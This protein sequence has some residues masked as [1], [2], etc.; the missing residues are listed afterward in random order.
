MCANYTPTRRDRWVEERFQ[1]GLPQAQWPSETYPGLAAPIIVLD[2]ERDLPSCLLA[3]F[4]L[5]P[6]WAKDASFGRRTYNAR[7]ETAAAKPSFRAAWRERRYALA[8]MDYFYEPRWIDHP[9]Q[10]VGLFDPVGF[11]RGAKTL[12]R[13][14]R[15]RIER[16]DGEPLAAASLWERWTDPQTGEIA[17]SFSMLTVNADDHALMKQ[18]HKPEDEKRMLVL[19]APAR[20][21]DWLRATPQ[22]AAQMM[23]AMPAQEFVAQAAP[24]ALIA[25]H[26]GLLV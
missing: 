14:V 20:Y 5:I 19:M 16:A 13:S 11:G 1:T 18:F 25:L 3:R 21:A 15:W 24:R 9:S 17:T 2:R 26:P 23:L 7:S 10:D 12:A 4:G 22:L 8:L 6:F